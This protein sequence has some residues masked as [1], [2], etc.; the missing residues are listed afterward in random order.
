MDF[1]PANVV[2]VLNTHQTD[3]LLKAIDFDCSRVEGQEVANQT[4]PS[5]SSPEVA[6]WLLQGSPLPKLRASHKM[7][8]MAFGWLGFEVLNPPPPPSPRHSYVPTFICA[9]W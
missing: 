7:V 2:R 9:L 5:Y 1:K 8:V 6:K 3:F 4:T